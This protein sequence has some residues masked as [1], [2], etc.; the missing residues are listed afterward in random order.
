VRQAQVDFY[1]QQAVVTVAAAQYDAAALL[2][3]LEKGGYKGRII[4]EGEAT[5]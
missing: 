3:A 4:T 2:K 5:G 1:H